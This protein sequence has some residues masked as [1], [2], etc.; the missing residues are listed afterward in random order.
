MGIFKQQG[1]RNNKLKLVTLGSKT[2]FEILSSMITP[3]ITAD[4]DIKK[5]KAY[6]MV[7]VISGSI[8]IDEDG[9]YIRN[10]NNLINRDLIFIDIEDIKESLE[11]A[12]KIIADKLKEYKYLLY[13]T[14]SHKEDKPRLRLVLEPNRPILKDEYKPTIM[15]IMNMIGLNYD[16]SSYTWSQLQGTPIAVKGIEPI[17]IKKLEGRPF[18]VIEAVQDINSSEHTKQ[19]QESTQNINN[20]VVSDDDFY[21]IFTEYLKIDYN[22]LYN[23]EYTYDR[24]LSVLLSLARGVC[25]QQFSYDIVIECS[26]LLA[27]QD[28]DFKDEYISNNLNK[29]NHAIKSWSNNKNYFE[30]EKSYTFF[31]KVQATKD[32][33]LIYLVRYKLNADISSNS[34]LYYRLNL[35]GEQWRE[36]HTTVNEKT[37]VEKVPLMQHYTVA[38]NLIRLLPCK[39]GGY[40]EQTALLFFYDF[41]K[42]IYTPNEDIL[43]KAIIKLEFRYK[44][45]N[46][47]P[48]IENMKTRVKFE[49]PERNPYLIAVGNGI[50]NFNTKEL[51]PFNPEHFITAKVDTNYNYSALK[52]YNE[53]KDIFFN[54]DDWFNE[55]ACND[56]EV[57]ELFWQLINEAANPNKTRRKIAIMY[58]GGKNGKSTFQSFLVNLIGVNNVSSITP[59]EIQSRFGVG[60]LEGKI[61]NYADEIGTKPLDEVDKLKSIASGEVISYERK[62]KDVRYYDFKTLLMFNSNQLP[63][64]K[65]KSEAVLERLLIIPFNANFKGVE[66][67]SIKDVK[68][69]DK[70]ILEYAL[71]KALNMDFERFTEPKIVKQVIEEYRKDND[72]IHAYFIDYLDRNLQHISRIPVNIIT[73]DYEQFCR[74]NGYSPLKRPIS[75]V[76]NKLNKKFKNDFYLYKI[77][78][79]GYTLDNIKELKRFDLLGKYNIDM[80]Q[81]GDVRKSLAQE[82]KQK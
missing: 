10:D 3:I 46:I 11:E 38:N 2:P 75:K 59:H 34:E 56:S 23:N 6:D 81:V 49:R 24:T 82:L 13:S 57:A 29:I 9:N 22:N 39:Y 78:N 33:S 65:E 62:N 60:G 18:E 20:T 40:D 61:C 44:L 5:Y 8:K 67:V 16:K 76:E 43:K 72:S 21:R 55:I 41:D 48:I 28:P 37:G 52:N 63:P 35:I 30:N 15:Y 74:E 73:A 14:I 36:E 80:L 26:E 7:Y 68:L 58:G 17:F 64:I 45:D 77:K 25:E 42:G 71:Y 27:T 66:D 12:I 53:I 51:E 47:K 54:L 19:P 31:D 1:Y 79:T 32:R 4:A 70:I 69:K 50:F